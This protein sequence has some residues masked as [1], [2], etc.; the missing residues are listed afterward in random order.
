MTSHFLSFVGAVFSPNNVLRAKQMLMRTQLSV[1]EEYARLF[2][3]LSLSL[4]FS[5]SLAVSLSQ[6]HTHPDTDSVPCYYNTEQQRREALAAAAVPPSL[7]LKGTKMLTWELFICNMS[8]VQNTR[9][10]D[11][12]AF[13]ILSLAQSY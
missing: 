13:I 8:G 3:S 7:T 9:T 4:S 5:L 6:T 2:L 11:P 12:W 1:R 10:A